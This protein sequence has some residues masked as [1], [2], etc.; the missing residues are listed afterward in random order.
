MRPTGASVDDFLAAVPA[1][2]RR[3]DG[4]LLKHMMDEVSGVSAVMWGPS[5]VGYG[6]FHY[7]YASGREGDMPVISFSPRKAAI[8]VYGLHYPGLTDS[9]APIGPHKTGEWCLYLGSF[10]QLNLMALEK[11]IRRAWNNEVPVIAD[12]FES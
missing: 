11:A 7:R 9:L 10:S 8:S 3:A 12:R 5:I 6:T 2:G 4:L 1:P